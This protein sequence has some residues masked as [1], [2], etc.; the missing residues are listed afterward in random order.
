MS[1]SAKHVE[2][3]TVM[4]FLDGELSQE[5]EHATRGHL[6]RCAR[7]RAA[8]EALKAE[9]AL[10]RAAVLEREEALP[11]H[12]RPR[13]ADV[14]WVLVAMIAFGTLAISTLWTRY[15]QPIIESMESIGLDGTSVDISCYS[16]NSLG[17]LLSGNS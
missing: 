3:L 1:D 17:R 16:R 10:M 14:S 4:R 5:R 15:V 9:T 13:H 7:C 11:G 2:E 12:L 6:I 8:H